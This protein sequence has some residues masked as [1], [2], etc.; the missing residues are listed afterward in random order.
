MTYQRQDCVLIATG[1]AWPEDNSRQRGAPENV[2]ENAVAYVNKRG[3]NRSLVFVIG[4]R[5]LY[6]VRNEDFQQFN[7]LDTGDEYDHKVCLSCG[8]LKPTED[9]SKNQNA[10]G[11][12]PVRR[13][14][15]K[16]CFSRDSGRTIPKD[17]RDQYLAD[18][19]PA[20][21]DLWQCPVCK[22]YSIAGVNVRI[23]VDH[24]QE[25]GGT[26]RVDLR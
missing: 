8:I 9:F 11:D 7:P 21:G 25:T 12:R 15:C 26:T 22:K 23:T 3:R 5:Q 1:R 2:G 4:K 6:W 13:P 20:T 14:R 18:H 10:K 16:L 19:G 17:I 24:N